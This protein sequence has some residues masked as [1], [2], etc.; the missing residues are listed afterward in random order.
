MSTQHF[1][2]EHTVPPLIRE[3]FRALPAPGEEFPL[4]HRVAWLTAA[5]ALL[6]LLY[7]PDGAPLVIRLEGTE[8]K[9]LSS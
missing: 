2:F 5:A 8:I 4:R 3:L 6:D 7:P 1:D 9:V